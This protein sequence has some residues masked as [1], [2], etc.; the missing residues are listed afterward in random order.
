MRG[1][2]LF[3][4]AVVVLQVM[5]ARLLIV[6]SSTDRLWGWVGVPQARVPDVSSKGLGQK[7]LS[8]ADLT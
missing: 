2:W 5:A 6:S 1:G 7:L 4:C 3:S 8:I